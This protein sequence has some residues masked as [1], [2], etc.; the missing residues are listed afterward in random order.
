MSTVNCLLSTIMHPLK[1]FLFTIFLLNFQA[2]LPCSCHN[3]IE[4]MN[5]ARY[6]DCTAAF[7]GIVDSVSP[8]NNYKSVTFS[9][10]IL[11]KGT[12]IQKVSVEGI[13]CNGPCA[14][15]FKKNETYLVYLFKDAQNKFAIYPCTGTRRVLSKEETADE[16]LRAE[17]YNTSEYL[18]KEIERWDH[19]MKFLEQMKNTP[20]GK[21]KTYYINGKL[22]GEGHF[23]NGIPMGEW[24]YYYPE[25]HLKAK[26]HYHNG[27]KTGEWIEYTIYYNTFEDT[28]AA[29]R[30]RFLLKSTGSYVH[31]LKEGKWERVNLDGSI[32]TLYYRKGKFIS[33][34][35]F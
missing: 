26:G 8:C 1:A 10:K 24:H 31:G 21:V 16:L 15:L 18:K 34:K 12:L 9:V 27:E 17:K 14:F 19:E 7:I 35:G 22:T 5:I 23:H 25:G 13:T 20:N 11:Y 30:K 3:D 28:A 6:N 4:E 33:E 32:Q 29:P 2:A